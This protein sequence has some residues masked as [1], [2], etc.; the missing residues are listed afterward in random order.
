M[1]IKPARSSECSASCWLGNVAP[2]FIWSARVGLKAGA[3]ALPRLPSEPMQVSCWSCGEVVDLPAGSR[4]GRRDTC[5]RCGLDLHSCRNCQ[6]YD[7]GK[8]NQCAETQAEWVRDK[9]TANICDYYSPRSGRIRGTPS[10]RK[11]DAK[12]RFDSLFKF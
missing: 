3:T 1:R 8:H 7:P 10:S 11:D 2:T 4:V 9:D 5:S 12:K 6:Y